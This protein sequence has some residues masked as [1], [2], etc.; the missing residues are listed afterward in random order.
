LTCGV[1]ADERLSLLID[2]SKMA[3]NGVFYVASESEDIDLK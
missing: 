2:D 3:T 1:V